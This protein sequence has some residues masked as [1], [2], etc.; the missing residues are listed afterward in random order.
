MMKKYCTLT[1]LRLCGTV[2]KY[3]CKHNATTTGQRIILSGK[4]SFT[5]SKFTVPSGTYAIHTIVSSPISL[6]IKRHKDSYDIRTVDTSLPVFIHASCTVI[7]D[8]IYTAQTPTTTSFDGIKLIKV[9]TDDI[10]IDNPMQ[11]EIFFSSCSQFCPTKTQAML[12][13]IPEFLSLYV[14]WTLDQ[15][16]LPCPF[17]QFIDMS[18]TKNEIDVN[19]STELSEISEFID[20]YKETVDSER[21]VRNLCHITKIL[22]HEQIKLLSLINVLND[23]IDK[24]K[25]RIN[26]L[27]SELQHARELR[28][29]HSSKLKNSLPDGTFT[30]RSLMKY[31]TYLLTVNFP[32]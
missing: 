30:R 21:A 19:K 2:I 32:V 14:K 11:K 31:L 20:T 1:D 28:D 13:M 8:L 5:L 26:A 10:S 22:K 25:K 4:R 6:T 17:N 23:H 9:I 29:S 7:L 24:T 15:S 16:N 12:L 18:I 27:A 3:D